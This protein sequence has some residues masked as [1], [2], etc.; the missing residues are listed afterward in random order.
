MVKTLHTAAH[1]IRKE[2]RDADASR[3]VRNQADSVAKGFERAAH[4]LNKHSYD[5]IT[6]DVAEGVKANPWRTLAIIFFIGLVI[7]LIL[8]GDDSPRTT[9]AASNET[10]RRP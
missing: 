2:A 7:G 3:E 1:T 5:D 8:R 9:Q 4:Y 6:E 10:Y